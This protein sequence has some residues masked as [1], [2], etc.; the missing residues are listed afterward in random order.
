MVS[1]E[2]C[3]VANEAQIFS[4]RELATATKDFRDESL[5]GQGGFGFV[6]KGLLKK[7]GQVMLTGSEAGPSS[8]MSDIRRR[9]RLSLVVPTFFRL[10]WVL[11]KYCHLSFVMC[12]VFTLDC[13]FCFDDDLAQYSSR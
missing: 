8:S 10:S 9:G 4:Y 6:Y 13:C 2:E 5:I 1:E 11:F 12:H 7:T 3:E